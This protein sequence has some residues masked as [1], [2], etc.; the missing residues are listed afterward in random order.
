MEFV[1]KKQNTGSVLNTTSTT[2]WR[3]FYWTLNGCPRHLIDFVL[4]MHSSTQ[5]F[6]IEE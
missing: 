4:H 1:L 2:P 3:Q 5:Y 6:R